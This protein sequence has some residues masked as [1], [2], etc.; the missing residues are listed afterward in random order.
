[1][2]SQD[3][4]EKTFEK[5]VFG[6]YDMG[7]VDDYLD[8]IAAELDAA[9]KE[10]MTLRAKLKVLVEKIEEYRQSEDAMRLTL[11]SAQKL[12]GQIENDA[13]A[14]ASKIL[15]EAN[16][17]AAKAYEKIKTETVVEQRR[18]M[19]AKAAIASYFEAARAS[20][21]RQLDFLDRLAVSDPMAEAK[22]TEAV[23]SIESQADQ[24]PAEPA[25]RI[26]F[27]VTMQDEAPAEKPEE[28]NM[29]RMFSYDGQN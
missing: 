21:N 9:Q 3:I 14:R 27:G 4:R 13:K 6:G 19:E 25:P 26:D 18:L 8:E 22:I 24:M 2:V 1:M 5:A 15:D 16:T 12:A 20:L 7:G 11:V 28:D 10:N 17:A 23:K 29:T